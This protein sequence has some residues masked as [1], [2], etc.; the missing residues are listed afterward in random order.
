MP[1]QFIAAN[2]H[3]ATPSKGIVPEKPARYSQGFAAIFFLYKAS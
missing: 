2:F 1:E 3:T